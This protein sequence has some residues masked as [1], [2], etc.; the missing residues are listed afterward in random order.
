MSIRYYFGEIDKTVSKSLLFIFEYI[1]I[2]IY[3]ALL[4][5]GD[6]TC[7]LENDS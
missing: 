1:Y 6:K 4:C 3:I 7:M 2:Y 5:V